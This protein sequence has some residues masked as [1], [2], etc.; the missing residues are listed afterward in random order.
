MKRFMQ[1]YVRIIDKVNYRIGRFAMYGI[2]A[3]LII[4]GWST[5]AKMM[6]EPS[7]WT[8]EMAQFAMVAYY[9]LGG[10]YAIQLGA[11]VRMDLVYG[12]WTARRK[13][14]FDA[15]TV[16]FLIFYLGV[17][18]YG[19]IDSTA[20]AFR[21]GERSYSL[22]QPYMWPVKVIM[23]VGFALML[24]QSVAELFK[25]LLVLTEDRQVTIEDGVSIEKGDR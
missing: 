16:T 17:L 6:D 24:V 2:F 18:L 15:F 12:S 21:T 25:D 19:A 5:I 3:M 9:V 7:M 11:N 4:L 22:W 1:G 14:W 20:Y 13:A 10:P 8:L 23:C